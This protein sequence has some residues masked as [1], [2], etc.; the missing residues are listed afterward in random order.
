MLGP[1]GLFLQTSRHRHQKFAAQAEGR[2][3]LLPLR[4]HLFGCASYFV[5]SLMS[6]HD[7]PACKC[8]YDRLE[9]PICMQFYVIQ[10]KE[11][12]QGRCLW[13]GLIAWLLQKEKELLVGSRLPGHK[14][15]PCCQNCLRTSGAF[16]VL[17]LHHAKTS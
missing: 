12:P 5:P 16:D 14:W 11:R 17:R 13:H 9:P 2:H 6:G 15:K 10:K 8:A 3:P 4:S 7:L 1:L